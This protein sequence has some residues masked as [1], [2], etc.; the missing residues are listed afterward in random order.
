MAQCCPV[1]KARLWTDPLFT[2][3]QLKCPRCGA[4]FRPTVAWRY[5]RTLLIV[6]VALIAV[7]LLLLPLRTFWLL[8]FLLLVTLSCSYLP[9][10]IDLQRMPG[11]L[12]LSEGPPL[13]PASAKFQI[14]DS[15]W[16][17]SHERRTEEHR[18]RRTL[19]VVLAVILGLL[20][21][22]RVAL[23]FGGRG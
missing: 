1:C 4:E 17:E 19:Y 9:R 11:S 18:A 10:L 14:E 6:A 13:D 23:H 22:L 3:D 20:L 12:Q 21:L 5:V 2:P 16:Q 8:I 7:V 15:R